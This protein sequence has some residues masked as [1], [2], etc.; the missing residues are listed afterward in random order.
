[1]MLR[2]SAPQFGFQK[3]VHGPH[4]LQDR[5]P[6]DDAAGLLSLAQMGVLEIQLWGS[7]AEE[8]QPPIG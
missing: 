7:T 4:R 2:E 3:S 6:V 8:F 1:M 5:Q